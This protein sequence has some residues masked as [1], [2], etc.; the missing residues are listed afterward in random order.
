MPNLNLQQGWNGIYVQ[1]GQHVSV[2]SP[3]WGGSPSPLP[4]NGSVTIGAN[5]SKPPGTILPVPPI[6]NVTLN[7][8]P[9]TLS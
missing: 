4:T 8:S 2:E 7:G 3:N 1:S 6:R 5:A 9:C